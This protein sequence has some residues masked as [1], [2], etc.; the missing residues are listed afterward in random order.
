MTMLCL[1]GLPN[2]RTVSGS[3]SG[4]LYVWDGLNCKKVIK[5]HD[6]NVNVLVSCKHGLL[7]GGKDGKVRLWSSPALEPGA[8]FDIAGLGSFNPR[9]RSL[10][11]SVDSLKIVVGTQGSEVYEISSADG[12]NLHPGPLVQGH[13]TNGLWGLAVHPSRPEFATVGDDQTVRVWDTHTKKLIK[14]AKL[15]TV[16]RAVAYSP[17]GVYLAVGLGSEGRRAKK[18]GAFVIIQEEDLTVIHEARDSKAWITDILF[19]PDGQTLAVASMDHSVYLYNVEDF[20]SKGRCRGHSAGVSHMDFSV[21][22]QWLRTNSHDW[23]L[24]YWNAGTGEQF[25]A[26]AGMK[27]VEWASCNTPLEWSTQGIW[28]KYNDGTIVNTVERSNAG[29]ILASGDSHG[30]IHLFRNPCLK[31]EAGRRLYS[32]HAAPVRR[33]RFTADDRTM[34]SIGSVDR[35]VFQ[36]RH[37]ADLVE[38]DTEEV[39]VDADSEDEAD[40]TDGIVLDRSKELERVVT[41]DMQ[42]LLDAT[43]EKMADEFAP[44]KP[45]VGSVVPPTNPPPDDPGAPHEGLTLDWVHGYRSLDVRG[46]LYYNE[47]GTIV[48]HAG[49]VNV[50]LHK[51]GGLY[52]QHHFAHTDDILCLTLHPE[53][54][55]AATGQVGRVPKIVIWDTET[56]ETVQVLEGFHRR[57]V[58]QLDFSRDGRR[59]AT[60][61]Q[62]ANHS[63][64][65]YE[66]RT[67][68]VTC[69]FEGGKEKVLGISHTPDGT[70]LVQVSAGSIL[71][72]QMDGKNATCKRALLGKKG[73]VQTFLCVGWCG[74]RPVVGTHD[75]HLYIFEGR[76]LL[77]SIAAHD[78]AVNCIH[79]TNEGLVTG[80]K[81]GKVRLW[82]VSM[83]P[84]GIFDVTAMGTCFRSSIRSVF[85]DLDGNKVLVGTRGSEILE[86]NAADGSD[87]NNGPLIQGHCQHQLWGLSMHPFRPE[88][89]TVGDD[90]T[91]RI[92]SVET[93]Q[94]LNMIKLDTMARA[95]AYAPDGAHIA[96]GLGG[97]IGR[98]RQK[99]DGA[100][101]IIDA[102]ELTIIHEA[103]DA[104][105]WI[106]DVKWSPDG[107]TLALAAHDNKVYL[108]DV[109]SAYFLRG[110]MEKHNSYVSHIDFSADGQYLQ[111]TCGAYEYLCSD[112]NT[113]T[114]IP[115]ISTLKDVRWDTWTCPLGWA[116]QGI[117]PTLEDGTEFTAA[118]RSKSGNLI[119]TADDFGRVKLH[120]YPCVTRGAGY[121][122]YVGHS[123]HVT[124]ARWSSD[125]EYVVTVGGNDRCI[126]QWKANIAELD[127]AMRAGESGVDSDLELETFEA[128]DTDDEPEEFM[129]VKPWVGAIVPPTNP[130]PTSSTEPVVDIEL[131]FVHG[132]TAQ[133]CRNNLFYSCKGEIVYHAA[134]VGIVYD[135]FQHAQKYYINHDDDILCLAADPTGRFVATGEEGPR[136]RVHVWS[137]M[138][139]QA[140]IVL[141]HFHVRGIPQ[142][143]FSPDGHQ[144]ISVG[145]DMNHSVCIWR[146]AS[147]TWQ[148]GEM[149]AHQQGSLETP[150]FAAFTG[151]E[152][153]EAMTGGVNHITFWKVEGRNLEATKGVFGRK[154]KIQPLLCGVS[155]RRKP[156]TGTATG[157]F[158]LWSGCKIEKA[159]KAHDSSV[160]ALFATAEGGFIVSGGKEGAVKLWDLNLT[161]VATYNVQEFSPVSLRPSVRAVCFD[162]RRAVLVVGTLGSEIYEICRVSGTAM[163]LTEGHCADELHGV[164][165]HPSD[166]NVFVTSGDDRT[167]RLWDIEHRKLSRKVQLDTMARSICFSPDG[168]MLGVGLGGNVGRGRQKKDGTVVVLNTE[169]LSIIHQS[170]D[171]REWI[172]ECKFS[173]DGKVFAIGSRDSKIYLYDVGKDLSLRAKC[174]KHSSFITHFDFS[175]DSDYLQ[176]RCRTRCRTHCTLFMCRARATHRTLLFRLAHSRL[177]RRR[178]VYGMV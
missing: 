152:A 118:D 4:H 18:N 66:W 63:I 108:Y 174:E 52:Q 129:A 125:D 157:H 69:A 122:E 176:V 92:W 101:V 46:N 165:T 6:K 19:S 22:N 48:Y 80:G 115:A 172:G 126:F 93:R 84:R 130:P 10:A 71:F 82:S 137:A 111:S 113:G 31:K 88:F 30:R 81:D 86:L 110:V 1:C 147:G 121:N 155:V 77:Q 44:V 83:E 25:K 178:V 156:L 100:Y 89:C 103:R 55:L 27:D 37:E 134:G 117:W 171:T 166:P 34:L 7:S 142:V 105:Q 5:A 33:I 124:N 85:W 168:N 50:A 40:L 79:A 42:R 146:S 2:G 104:K 149:Q 150:L 32:G 26:I 163:L 54:K 94:M 128:P 29:N 36:W 59:I 95:C 123:S 70:G 58:C 154:G 109:G 65:V 62:D 173:P 39:K 107:Q 14:M 16:A 162:H 98:G 119:V 61:G 91:V 8:V 161:P 127:D 60:V 167:I 136:P 78:G 158:Y 72:H 21:D 106:S 90:K 175:A 96:V 67:G 51:E 20:A 116:V 114:V 170:R 74:N 177:G 3:V 68:H 49:C 138:D 23:E 139:G 75:G 145:K 135:K 87:I 160:N 148:D 41:N 112:P 47:R 28:P 97:R 64:A 12:S 9:V 11:W 131:D 53:G 143:A 76:S 17:D 43:E 24:L 132:Y 133:H 56:M 35:C 144:I 57:A 15:D 38:D 99:K 13:C 141:P 159:I 140:I 102:N 164:A 120:R 151:G 153:Q 73:K 169:S 45:W